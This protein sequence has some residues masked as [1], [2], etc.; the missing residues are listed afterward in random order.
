[1][2]QQVSV[3]AATV[4]RTTFVGVIVSKE[5]KALPKLLK[6]VDKA[7]FTAVLQCKCSC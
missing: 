7:L 2:S 4:E 1:M 3:P 6:K 5:I